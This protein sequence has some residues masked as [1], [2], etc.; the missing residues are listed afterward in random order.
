[1]AAQNLSTIVKLDSKPTWTKVDLGDLN[2]FYLIGVKEAKGTT[3][4][5]DPKD[6]KRISFEAGVESGISGA[7][8][9]ES[10]LNIGY[11]TLNFEEFTSSD[12]LLNKVTAMT[13]YLN[14]PSVFYIRPT[15]IF[16]DTQKFTVG[17]TTIGININV[18]KLN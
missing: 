16:T 1:M 10:Y 8:G 4:T 7:E 11:L 2:S 13:R 14:F 12:P 15:E 17:L 18:V 6:V 9:E 5:I 3:D